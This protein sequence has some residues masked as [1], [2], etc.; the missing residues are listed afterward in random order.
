[1]LYEA[2]KRVIDIVGSIVGLIIF[3]PVMVA[4]AIAIKLDSPEGPVFADLPDRVGK[5]R[6]PFK[7]FKFRS[8]IPNAHILMMTDPKFKSFYNKWRKGQGKLRVDEDPR[9]TRVGR[10]IRKTDLDETPQFLNILLGQM[11]IVGPRAYFYN[12]IEEYEKKYPKLRKEIDVALSV[13]PGLT[14]IWQI[15]GRNEISIPDRL[16][17][18]AE[19]ARKKNIFYDL[20]IIIRTPIVMIT[21]KGALE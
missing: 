8:M 12:D 13:K 18:D 11:S 16:K 4:F 1:M 3:S 5:G 17:L 19:Y 2:A 15:S 21:R 7:M 6:K 9:I 20:S 14:G 10:F